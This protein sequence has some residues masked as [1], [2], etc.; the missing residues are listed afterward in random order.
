MQAGVA[1]KAWSLLLRLRAMPQYSH[2]QSM[3]NLNFR[4]QG[5]A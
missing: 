5:T 2:S 1:V 3:R 4:M